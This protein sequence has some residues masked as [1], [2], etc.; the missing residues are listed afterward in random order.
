MHTINT[1]VDLDL[2]AENQNNNVLLYLT[3][4]LESVIPQNLSNV[5]TIKDFSDL[6]NKAFNLFIYLYKIN[7]PEPFYN[8]KKTLIY[9]LAQYE[10]NRQLIIITVKIVRNIKIKF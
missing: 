10:N 2:I 5:K 8:E 3:K 9:K 7:G 1:N 4:T 6:V